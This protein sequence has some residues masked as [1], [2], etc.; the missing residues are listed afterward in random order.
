MEDGQACIVTKLFVALIVKEELALNL[1]FAPV[2]LDG[3]VFFVRS[4]FAV[5]ACMVFVLNQKNVSAFMDTLV[6]T[7]IFQLVCLLAITVMQHNLIL[8][9]VMK[10]GKAVFVISQC[11]IMIVVHKVT[12]YYQMFVSVISDGN[13]LIY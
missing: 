4:V 9:L 8:V 2:N 5:S 3:K 10:A 6:R 1:M 7:V 12:A 11:V 13:L